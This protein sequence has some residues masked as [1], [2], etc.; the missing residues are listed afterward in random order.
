M[1]TVKV[2]LTSP[3]A[4]P[5]LAAAIVSHFCIAIGASVLHMTP[6]RKSHAPVSFAHAAPSASGAM[7]A[8]LAALQ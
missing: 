5:P 7:Q 1:Q 3:H 4:W 6:W 8:L 2:L